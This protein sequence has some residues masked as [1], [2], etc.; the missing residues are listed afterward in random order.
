VTPAG[1]AADSQDKV[2][3]RLE[4]WFQAPGPKTVG[5]LADV[6]QEKSFAVVFII[7]M[8]PT[9]L[10]LPTGGLTYVLEV[11]TMLVALELVIGRRT[12]WLP[13]RWKR[14]ELTGSSGERV[15]AS[16]LK[17]IRRLERFSR[18]R[19][20]RVLWNPLST[21]LFGVFVF[22]LTLIASAAPPFSGLDTLPAMGV[23]LLSLGVLL[24]DFVLAAAGLVVGAVGTLLVFLLGSLAVDLVGDLF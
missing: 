1:V 21:R 8:A 6:F 11:M 23:V 15:A 7:L 17:W 2:S 10:P 3:D 14:M 13:E 19:L 24:E 22:A 4:R 9:A 5:S 12:V 20:R 18:P 16:L